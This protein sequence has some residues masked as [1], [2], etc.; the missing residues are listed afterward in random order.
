MGPMEPP[1]YSGAAGPFARIETVVDTHERRETIET[2]LRETVSALDPAPLTARALRG[3]EGPLTIIAIGKAAAAMC[4]GAELAVGEV[5][6]ICVTTDVSPVPVGI[7]LMVGEHPIPGDRSFEAGERVIDSVRGATHPLL[8]LISG[9]GSSLCER[10]LEGVPREFV[11]EATRELLAAG[12]SIGD[13]NL[14]RRHLSAI[15]GG[16]LNRAAGSP[17]ETFAL[18][19][20][21]GADP[22]VIASGP[23]VSQPPDPA[24]ALAVLSAHGIAVPDAVKEAMSAGDS[25]VSEPALVTVIGDG[26][27]AARS[28]AT[29]AGAAGLEATI[30]PGWLKGDVTTAL[31]D[32]LASAAETGLTI[33][34]GEV[35]VA[36]TGDGIG[37]RNTHVGLLAAERIAGSSTTFAAFATDGVDGHSQAAGAIVDGETTAR[38]GDPRPAI[39]ASDSASYLDATGDLIRTGPTGTNVSDL[40]VVWR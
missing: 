17:I 21:C 30:Q 16:G 36:V 12:A 33:A 10:P 25:A 2:L 26:H 1:H 34:V 38:G 19:D 13:F 35:D 4:R 18:S 28:L 8:A 32:F 40:W 3:R 11:Q 9:G 20:V 6:G 39:A 22:A 14:V 24:G 7:D 31:D 29:A 5:D 37:G 15:K 23:T 27:T